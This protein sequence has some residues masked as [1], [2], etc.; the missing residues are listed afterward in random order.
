MKLVEDKWQTVNH[1]E[2]GSYLIIEMNG[3]KGTF[4]IQPDNGNAAVITAASA[5]AITSAV[6]VIIIIFTLKKKKSAG[7]ET[8]S[9]PA[10]TRKRK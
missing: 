6:I 1:T 9:M 3:T 7:S 10:K 4:C 8:K 2:N 5:A